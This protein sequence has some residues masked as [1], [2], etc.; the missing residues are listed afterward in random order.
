MH[1]E[2]L[3]HQLCNDMLDLIFRR[4]FFHNDH[5]DVSPRAARRR[6]SPGSRSCD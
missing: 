2:S 1:V 4:A 6:Y 5:H 3:A